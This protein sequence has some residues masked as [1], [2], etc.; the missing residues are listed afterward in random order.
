MD[1]TYT[2]LD[3]IKLT[4]FW[5]KST[6]FTSIIRHRVEY[7]SIFLIFSYLKNDNYCVSGF[8]CCKFHHINVLIFR[9][10]KAAQCSQGVLILVRD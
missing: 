6:S 2:R 10:N 1:S 7:D 5:N 8:F 3:Y 9:I 4:I